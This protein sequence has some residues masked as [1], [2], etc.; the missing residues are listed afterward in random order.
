MVDLTIADREI[1]KKLKNIDSGFSENYE[2]ITDPD[3]FDLIYS[4]IKYFSYDLGVSA[5]ISK[6]KT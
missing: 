5:R 6:E 4:L 1:I 3:H 2:I